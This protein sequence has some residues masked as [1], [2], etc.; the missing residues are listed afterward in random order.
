MLQYFKIIQWFF[1]NDLVLET[2]NELMIE[3]ETTI[4]L[5][6]RLVYK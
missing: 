5:E 6:S 1:Q 2:S 4:L 3:Q